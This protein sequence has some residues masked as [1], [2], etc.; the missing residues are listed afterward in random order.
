MK[1]Y[2][3]AIEETVNDFDEKHIIREEVEK[4]YSESKKTTAKNKCKAKEK[5]GK[6]YKYRLHNCYHE[7]GQPC[8]VEYIS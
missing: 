6:T 1:K 4:D 7:E 2:I 3:Q 5:A 8:T